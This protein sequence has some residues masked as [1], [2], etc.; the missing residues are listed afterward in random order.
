M[1]RKTPALHVTWVEFNDLSAV[2][3]SSGGASGRKEYR[4]SLLRFAKRVL[5]PEDYAAVEVCPSIQVQPQRDIPELRLSWQM[6][7]P[8]EPST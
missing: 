4:E 6:E 3:A 2:G 8:E 5:R 1:T 7:L